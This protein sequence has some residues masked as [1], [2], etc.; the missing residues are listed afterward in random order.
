MH[1]AADRRRQS[2]TAEQDRNQH[3]I[4]KL[5]T[6]EIKQLDT[7]TADT[8]TNKC[9]ALPLG[10]LKSKTRTAEDTP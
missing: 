3:A 10:I 9:P 8:T 5:F 2:A 1:P 4:G 6:K 7:D